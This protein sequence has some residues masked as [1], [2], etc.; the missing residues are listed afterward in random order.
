MILGIMPSADYESGTCTIPAGASLIML[1]DGTY[2]VRTRDGAMLEFEEF[3]AFMGENGTRP[4]VFE[5]VLSWI[6]SLRSDGPL[7]DD[8]SLVRIRFP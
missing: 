1:C 6:H 4:D 3:L 8:F 7:D 5:R 2:E